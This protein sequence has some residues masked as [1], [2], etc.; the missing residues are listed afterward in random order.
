VGSTAAALG[1][2][3]RRHPLLAAGVVLVAAALGAAGVYWGGWYWWARSHYR[4]AQE[5][6]DRHDWKAAREHVKAS[7]R[8]WPNSADTHLLAA[9]VDRRLDDLDEAEEQ[10]DTCQRLQGRETQAIRV[11]RSLVRV[12]RR[13]LATEEDFLRKCIAA[14]DPD[15]AE[16]LDILSAALIIDYRMAEAQGCLDNLLQRR[17]N[18]FDALVRRGKTAESMGWLEDAVKH[19]DRA[20]AL[21]PEV[22]NVRLAMAEVQ[23]ALGKYAEAKGHFER[24]QQR[25]P[26]NPS[27]RFGMARCLAG[28]GDKEQREQ[29]RHLLDQLLAEY[30]EDW[31]ALSER[32]WLAVQM[33]RPAEG[34]PYLRKAYGLAPPDLPLVV[35]LAD[36]LR[37]VGKQD[38]ADKYRAEA[39]RIKADIQRAAELGDTIRENKPDDPDLRCELARVL[40]RLGKK[41]DAEHWFQTALAKNPA[42]RKAH[43]ALV[44]LY[45]SVGAWDQAAQHR[46]FLQAR[47]GANGGTPH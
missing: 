7:L 45:E 3:K 34:E 27:V 6:A 40:L 22:D 47:D 33:E 5:A 35:R 32:G 21:R 9:R 4:A 44:Q 18:D 26:R 17:P 37:L 23:V 14:D 36:C 30:P 39:D 13:Q 10:L 25:Q 43:E 29:A 46:Q 11:E 16:I 19:Y 31:K 12:Y 38:E 28:A 20:L 42:H 1:A 2:W 24:L 8:G 15:A 41:Q